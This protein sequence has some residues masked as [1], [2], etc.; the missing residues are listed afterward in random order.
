MSWLRPHV[1]PEY[2]VWRKILTGEN[3]DE[4]DEFPTIHQYFSYQNFTF[5]HLPLMNLWRSGPKYNYISEVP[6]KVAF[7]TAAA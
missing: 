2:T 6:P 3:I 4:F 1:A 5:S 7:F